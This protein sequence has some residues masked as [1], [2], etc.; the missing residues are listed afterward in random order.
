MKGTWE[1]T[2][3]PSRLIFLYPTPY[4]HSK[5]KRRRSIYVR[6]K[7]VLYRMFQKFY[8]SSQRR[9]NLLSMGPELKKKKL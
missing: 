4:A 3:G 2:N 1:M 5:K 8:L 9:I 6:L 7:G